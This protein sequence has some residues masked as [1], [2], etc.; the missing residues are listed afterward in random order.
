MEAMRAFA[1]CAEMMQQCM[2][3]AAAARGDLFFGWGY[4]AGERA[5][6]QNDPAARWTLLLPNELA[7]RQVR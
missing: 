4:E 3:Y 2:R 5:G 7:A 1:Q 6:R